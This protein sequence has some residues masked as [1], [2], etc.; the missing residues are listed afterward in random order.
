M[1]SE[2]I[3]N[4]VNILEKEVHDQEA[5]LEIGR[6]RSI[7][8]TCQDLPCRVEALCRSLSLSFVLPLNEVLWKFATEA[9]KEVLSLDS[10]GEQVLDAVDDW[11][12]NTSVSQIDGLLIQGLLC[13]FVGDPR[14]ARRW[15]EK[16]LKLAASL[17]QPTYRSWAEPI[18]AFGHSYK[19]DELRRQGKLRQAEIAYRKAVTLCPKFFVGW[20]NLGSVLIDEG[21]LSEALN[22]CKRALE[23]VPNWWH[24]YQG[25]GNVYLRQG[26]LAKAEDAFQCGLTLFPESASLMANL[27]AVLTLQ[28]KHTSSLSICKRATSLNPRNSRVWNNFAVALREAG[29]L[30]EGITALHRAIE[31]DPLSHETARNLV[32]YYLEANEIPTA[33]KE[34]RNYLT[35]QLKRAR[36]E[37][38]WVARDFSYFARGDF[39]SNLDLLAHTDSEENF[40]GS[41]KHIIDLYLTIVQQTVVEGLKRDEFSLE[42]AMEDLFYIA[43]LWCWYAEV[44]GQQE[45]LSKQFARQQ[46]YAIKQD[47][48]N[49]FS[50][51]VQVGEFASAWP[52][53][54]ARMKATS[55][56]EFAQEIINYEQDFLESASKRQ[57]RGDIE[58]LRWRLRGYLWVHMF[59][60]QH[61]EQD[62]QRDEHLERVHY[63]IE[64]LKGHTVLHKLAGPG[65]TGT[66][67][68]V[69]MRNRYI[70]S[71]PVKIDKTA[72]IDLKTCTNLLPPNAVALS[73]YFLHRNLLDHTLLVIVNK[74]GQI[75]FLKTVKSTERLAKFQNAAKHL[76]KL[77]HQV[78]IASPKVL[79][80]GKRFYDLLGIEKAEKENGLKGREL[81]R[82]IDE[83]ERKQLRQAYEAILE[84]VVD[85]EELRGKDL[86]I[87][88]SPEMYDIPFNLFLKGDEFLNQIV[89]SI[90]I[91]P[92]FS[93][94]Q[95][96]QNGYF[97]GKSGLVLSLGKG[98]E[99]QAKRRTQSLSGWC[100]EVSRQKIE[101]QLS[102][103]FPKADIRV[104]Y[105]GLIKT[106]VEIGKSVAHVI[107]DN[108]EW[109][110]STEQKANLGQFGRYLYEASEKLSTDL[111][112]LEACWGGT[113]S[114]SEDLMGLFVSFLASGVSRVIASPYS[115]VPASTSGKLFD[116]IY[117]RALETKKGNIGLQIACAIREASEEVRQAIPNCDDT[118][119]TLWGAY[120]VY[121]VM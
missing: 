112:S 33:A 78:A 53:L 25:I 41:G 56:K 108:E 119:P 52:E 89:N 72:I 27:G 59:E 95:F 99:S 49:I 13:I 117:G 32:L 91:V 101:C 121:G 47:M 35:Y 66:V 46:L 76:K 84:G 15:A 105:D 68:D 71:L 75:P 36:V 98:W 93:L 2:A 82:A 40:A 110:D 24:A 106:I 42:K 34:L 10:D 26:Q 1:K 118:I 69:K 87:S 23:V 6:I 3:N 11:L 92:I 88:P 17:S 120:Q 60:Y 109:S 4:L 8:N 115:V 20:S 31:C 85:V 57:E 83:E 48:T 81:I 74:H 29:R 61:S 50:Q 30:K 97:P 21:K 64:L 80:I 94:Q 9:C 16:A 111:L 107:G 77:H 5:I 102:E 86:Y 44:L 63:Y 114:D 28:G 54:Q 38:L 79:K 55:P 45:G 67:I 19:G 39:L 116:R 43:M 18:C 90:T 100:N 73:F 22:A 65:T 12:V 62:E 104:I 7:L 51:G 96:Q 103:S 70:Q 37:P 58:D 14:T 113:W